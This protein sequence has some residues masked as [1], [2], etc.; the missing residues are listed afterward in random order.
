MLWCSHCQLLLSVKSRVTVCV[1]LLSEW[2][3]EEGTSGSTE[4][5][6]EGS[7]FPA[8]DAAGWSWAL[9]LPGG[10]LRLTAAVRRHGETEGGFVSMQTS[11]HLNAVYRFSWQ[12]SIPVSLLIFTTTKVQIKTSGS[13]TVWSVFEYFHK[14][15]IMLSNIMWCLRVSVQV[16]Y[17]TSACPRFCKDKLFLSYLLILIKKYRGYPVITKLYK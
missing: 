4:G 14:H 3:G 6:T 12:P 16:K 13:S 10:K 17:L 11:Q 2:E 7:H 5:K 9:C 1:F 15:Y 8:E